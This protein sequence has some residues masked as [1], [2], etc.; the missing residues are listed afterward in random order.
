MD[1]ALINANQGLSISFGGSSRE[2]LQIKVMIA[3][4]RIATG[5]TPSVGGFVQGLIDCETLD[6][7]IN[8]WKLVKLILV[9]FNLIII[10]PLAMFKLISSFYE[11]A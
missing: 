11:A 5:K 2:I 9:R 10:F 8:F 7:C 3:R 4:S 6:Y 1:R